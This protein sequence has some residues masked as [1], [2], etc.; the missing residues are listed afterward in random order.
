[1]ALLQGMKCVLMVLDG[2]LELLDV[3]GAPLTEC[4]LS[5]SIPLLALFRRSIDLWLGQ[6]GYDRATSYHCYEFI[7]KLVR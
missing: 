6:H 2:S 5:L 7:S 3:L 1:M 4:S